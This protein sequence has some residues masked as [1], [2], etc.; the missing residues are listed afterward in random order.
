[1]G[2]RDGKGIQQETPPP[3]AIIITGAKSDHAQPKNI[4]IQGLACVSV[5]QPQQWKGSC[6]I[7]LTQICP[8][9]L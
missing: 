4:A 7:L 2:G 9:G 5:N 8:V 3:K 6:P 1:M